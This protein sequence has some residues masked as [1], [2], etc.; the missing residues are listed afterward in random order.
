MEN[1]V[2]LTKKDAI[3]HAN[4]ELCLQLNRDN[5][6]GLK[7]HQKNADTRCGCGTT[8]CIMFTVYTPNKDAH[9]SAVW[10]EGCG[11]RNGDL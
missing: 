9:A 4:V 3:Y 11:S 7:I 8:P 1:R 5:L 6:K 10:C 2:F